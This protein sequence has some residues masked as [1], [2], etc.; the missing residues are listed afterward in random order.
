MSET[1]RTDAIMHL[2]NRMVDA[3]GERFFA[4]REGAQNGISAIERE[5]ALVRSWAK[6][7]WKRGH[8]MGMQAN[9][10]A[11]QAAYRARD[12]ALADAA[13]TNA[14]LTQVVTDLE[15]KLAA[16]EKK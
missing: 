5:L 12:E 9:E 8:A 11:A 15:A 7:A 10:Q 4:L 6:S 1:P 2:V 13:H 3:T 16:L 14:L